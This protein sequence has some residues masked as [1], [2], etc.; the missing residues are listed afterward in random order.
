MSHGGHPGVVHDEHLIVEGA[1]Q[2]PA[3]GREREPAETTVVGFLPPL[4]I[5]DEDP[6]I[7]TDEDLLTAVCETDEPNV[8][9]M[10][11]RSGWQML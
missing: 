7:A 3:I 9:K 6:G 11:L 1:G 8:G 10:T 5:P 4:E 2:A